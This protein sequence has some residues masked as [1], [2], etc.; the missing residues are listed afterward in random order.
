MDRSTLT[1]L[2][3]TAVKRRLRPLLAPLAYAAERPRMRAFYGGIVGAGDLVFDV[4]AAE[5]YHA[6]VLAG[7]GARVVCLEPQPYCLSVLERRFAGHPRVR[8]VAAGVGAEPGEA[9]LHVSRGDPEISTFGVDKWRSGRFAGFAWEDR[10]T[11]PVVTLDGLI[12]EHGAPDL[13]KVDV[14]GWEPK[15]L[16]GLGRPLPWLSFEFTREFLDDARRCVERL[17]A[18][19]PTEF[20]A[21]LFRRW[22]FG[23]EGWVAG[24]ELLDALAREPRGAL[25]GDI[26]AR[27]ASG[28]QPPPAPSDSNR[29]S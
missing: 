18:L 23:L 28:H 22:R 17:A 15:V 13:V 21:T 16:A 3:P 26:H 11:V 2:L 12:A 10:I 29:A 24:D 8:V 6:A 7:L 4:G 9:T 5:G 25:F 19:G 20:N 1:R 27:P 14:E